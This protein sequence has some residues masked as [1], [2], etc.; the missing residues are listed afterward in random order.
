MWITPPFA[1]VPTIRNPQPLV[2]NQGGVVDYLYAQPLT[3]RISTANPRGYP[4]GYPHDLAHRGGLKTHP[5]KDQ[6]PETHNPNT[7]HPDRN[8]PT[9]PHPH[10]PT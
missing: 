6:T 7:P 8:H 4:Q 10:H 3:H 1:A 9:T 2:D 5:G